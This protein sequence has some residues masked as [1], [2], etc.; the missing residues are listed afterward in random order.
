[1]DLERT[2]QISR[3]CAKLAFVWRANAQFSLVELM[4]RL[5]GQQPTAYVRHTY[6]KGATEDIDVHT[7][8]VDLS[9]LSDDVVEAKLDGLL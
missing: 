7:M 3:I 9:A 2:K 4:E 8:P 6:Q 5:S 1:M